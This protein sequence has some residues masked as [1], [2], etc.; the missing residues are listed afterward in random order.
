[1][2]VTV[3]SN[4]NNISVISVVGNID[5]YSSPKLRDIISVEIKKKSP[6]IMV[7]LRGVNYM[8]SS[9]IATFV[10]SFKNIKKYQGKFILF[11][12]Q[13][14]VMDILKM[15]KL[16]NVFEIYKNEEEALKNGI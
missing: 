14:L 9:G 11:N 7:D 15:T 3:S 16:N 4:N 1:M 6:T 2:K 12:L 13:C 8:D 10:E 5:I